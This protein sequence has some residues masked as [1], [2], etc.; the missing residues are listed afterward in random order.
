MNSNFSKN[1]NS[2]KYIKAFT[3]AEV[4]ITLSIIGV[5]A[6]MTIPSL[7]QSTQNAE[8]VA[9]VK[10]AYATI[11]VAFQKAELD[12][13]SVAGWGWTAS[14]ASVGAQNV[15]DIL[16]PYLNISKSCGTASLHCFPAVTYKY[17]NLQSMS[18]IDG[19]TAYAKAQLLDGTLIS[20]ISRSSDCS[21]DEFGP[22]GDT[23]QLK[24]VC[25]LVFW[26]INGQNGPNIIA[27]DTFVFYITKYGVIPL[28]TNR[29]TSYPLSNCSKSA[30]TQAGAACTAWVLEKGNMDY[31]K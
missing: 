4:L 28:G 31:L 3:L 14:G 15:F 22:R 13:G 30:S 27:K 16:S 24:N 25:G 8:T 21:D 17:L 19:S 1:K 2:I 6:A 10:K 9:K 12:N 5:V 20:F 23:P 11:S 7:K 29:D 18:P 26:D